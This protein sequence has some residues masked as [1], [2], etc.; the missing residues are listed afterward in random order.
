VRDRG[1]G[2]E[3]WPTLEPA[4]AERGAA[5]WAVVGLQP[6]AR[7]APSWVPFPSFG[8]VRLFVARMEELR[9]ASGLLFVEPMLR[10]PQAG[11]EGPRACPMDG[12]LFAPGG[13][14]P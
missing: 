8:R 3:R 12:R 11:P 14:R 6:R 5:G 2:V 7:P 1:Y 4:A 13:R 9:G 10:R